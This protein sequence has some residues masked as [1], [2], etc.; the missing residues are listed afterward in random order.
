MASQINLEGNNWWA[1]IDVS[2]VN[3][4]HEH[5]FDPIADGNNHEKKTRFAAITKKIIELGIMEV[6]IVPKDR[7]EERICYPFWIGQ[8][9]TGREPTKEEAKKKMVEHLDKEWKA[10]SETLDIL[11]EFWRRS[12]EWLAQR[13]ESRQ[14]GLYREDTPAPFET[15][16]TPR[17]RQL[18][19]NEL[20]EDT[21]DCWL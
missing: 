12:R 10:P 15:P 13:A 17:I 14:E 1:E 4:S 21:T 3:S 19:D 20:P 7:T 2:G 9:P 16:P 8:Y 11:E 18:E 6:S 5:N